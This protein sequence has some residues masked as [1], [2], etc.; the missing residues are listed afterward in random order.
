[1]LEAP[2]QMRWNCAHHKR[3]HMWIADLP[4]QVAQDH[5]V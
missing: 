3:A 5:H 1:V 4:S 2:D